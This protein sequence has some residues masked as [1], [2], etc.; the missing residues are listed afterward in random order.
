MVELINGRGEYPLL[1]L[2][3]NK[4]MEK[5]NEVIKLEA[6]VTDKKVRVGMHLISQK[7]GIIRNGKVEQQLGLD[8]SLSE[9]KALHA[10]LKLLDKTS[11]RGNIEGT[12]IESDENRMNYS[13][14]LPRITCTLTE[15]LEAYGLEK[16]HTNRG[17]NEFSPQL[18]EEAMDALRSLARNRYTFVYKRETFSKREKEIDR[19]EAEVPLISVIKGYFGL[20]EK[21]NNQLERGIEDENTQKKL[22]LGIEFGPIFVDQIDGYFV[23]IPSNLYTDIKKV[24]GK[25]YSSYIP[26]FIEWLIM[27]MRQQEV[28]KT[29]GAELKINTEKIANILRMDAAG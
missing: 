21:E 17:F 22:L 27:R 9:S 5:Q 16:K 18:R 24:V 12:N 6:S 8:L 15:Y 1:H 14:V 26:L 13:G 25:K 2:I 3:T 23:L 20:T 7:F 28:H 11:Y 19:I 10:L 29:P 4:N